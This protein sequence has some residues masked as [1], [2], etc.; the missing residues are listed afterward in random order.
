M[1]KFA[2]AFALLGTV[3]FVGCDLGAGGG[4][5]QAQSYV[6][7]LVA[8]VTRTGDLHGQIL[9]PSEY[10]QHSIRF[11]LDDVTFV[12]HP[13]GR[14][15][16]TNVPA[17]EHQLQV[18]IKGYEPVA[19]PVQVA[20][21]E[22]LKVQPVRLVEALGR[23]VGRLVRDKGGSAEGVEVRLVPDDGVAVTD[24]DGIFQFLGVSGGDHTLQVK[25]PRFFASNQHFSL[26]NNERRNL[27]NIRVYRQTRGDPQTARLQN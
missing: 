17:G 21:G 10:A 4:D 2:I 27:G 13:D 12:T 20:Q 11:A 14:F 25:D 3:V 18:R 24:R 8:F 22:E 6:N 5:M 23:V 1:K 19:L 15:R 26:T 16:I 9:F 7:G